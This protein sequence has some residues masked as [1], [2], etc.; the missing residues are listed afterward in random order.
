MDKIIVLLLIFYFSLLVLN[1]KI[2]QIIVFIVL[3]VYL[4]PKIYLYIKERLYG[5][6]NYYS[7]KIG[8]IQKTTYG[9]QIKYSLYIRIK[10]S[11]HNILDYSPIQFYGHSKLFI[12]GIIID[13]NIRYY[14]IYLKDNSRLSAYIKISYI[15]RKIDDS[16]SKLKTIYEYLVHHLESFGI[17]NEISDPIVYKYLIKEKSLDKKYLFL[18]IIPI[19]FSFY[20][21][22]VK[23]TV[24]YVNIIA[25]YI[26]LIDLPLIRDY[27]KNNEKTMFKGEILELYKNEVIQT[28]PTV[29]EI[30][31]RSRWIYNILNSLKDFLI[32][33]EIRSASE[34]IPQIIE[35]KSYRKYELATAL[36]KL[37]ILSSAEKMYTISQRRLNKREN[38]Y[39]IRLIVFTKT[40]YEKDNIKKVL[41]S[42]GF[43]MKKPLYL[44]PIFTMLK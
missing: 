44:T 9:K 23:L 2:L 12:D 18:L 30:Y 35:S 6:P 22:F 13:P 26:S 1:E 17:V 33:L 4:Y 15:T 16:F 41:F 8:K 36:D 34:E 29:N 24:S 37:S 39:N 27:F 31:R 32:I 38:F 28:V 42:I 40:K 19:L 10:D 20:I 43:K 7:E 14:L 5:L 25:L 3:L 21:F 11:H